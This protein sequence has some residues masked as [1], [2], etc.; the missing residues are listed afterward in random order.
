MLRLF[1][2]VV[3]DGTPISPYAWRVRLT[4]EKLGLPFERVGVGFTEIRT[5]AGGQFATVP[6]L[7]DGELF[8]ADSWNIADYL[9]E[10]YAEGSLLGSACEKSMIRFVDRW[11]RH[12]LLQPLTR[13][14]V[15]DILSRLRPADQAYFRQSREA[16]LGARLEQV[17]AERAGRI[18]AFR[19]ELE[20]LRSGLSEAPFVGGDEPG[21]A[22]FIAAAALIWAGSVCTTRLLEQD[23][24]VLAWFERCLALA[25]D[26]GLDLAFPGLMRAPSC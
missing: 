21:Y 5:I 20:P 12:R 17:V 15:L 8:I 1:E 26:V 19:H 11:C 14:C 18:V 22:D 10:R 4:L 6:V 23:D 3:E 7:Q 25:G 2:L 9:D 16:R 13:I 24:P